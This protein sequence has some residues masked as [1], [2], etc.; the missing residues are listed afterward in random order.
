GAFKN[1]QRD[2]E[3]Y[4]SLGYRAGTERVDRQRT[5]E[6]RVKNRNYN[7][8]SRQ[9]FVEK[10]T[11][12]EMSDRVIANLLYKTKANDLNVRVKMHTPVPQDELFRVPVEIQIPMES[13]TLLPQGEAYLGGFSIYVAVANKDNDMSDVAQKQQQIRVPVADMGKI[14]G[15]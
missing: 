1:I 5:I 13:L 3:S 11:F 14:K 2:L 4:Y 10:S 8:R 9:T 12:A 7:V 6:V 15:K